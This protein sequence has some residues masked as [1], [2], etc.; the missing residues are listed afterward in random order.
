MP[1][2]QFPDKYDRE[3]M[4]TAIDSVAHRSELDGV[5]LDHA[6]LVY[7]THIAT[8]LRSAFETEPIEGFGGRVDRIKGTEVGIASGFGIGGPAV[9]ALVEDL[10]AIGAE[11]IV[12]V[13][14][15][16]QLTPSESHVLICEKALRDEGTSHH[17]APDARFA[18]P[19]EALTR[20]IREHLSNER[21][22]VPTASSWT[23][24]ALYRET[25][26]ERDAYL[27]EGITCVEMEAASLFTVCRTLGIRCASVFVVS[28]VSEGEDHRIAFHEPDVVSTLERVAERMLTFLI[29]PTYRRA[30]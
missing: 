4:L 8:H 19:D 25:T 12:S 20:M 17:Y 10:H 16:G 18:Y 13:G 9:A 24:D 2:P 1:V 28:D 3:V 26:A 6:L 11:T 7:R 27:A 29:D 5:R 21:R 22:G 14:T 30:A 15:C 23:T